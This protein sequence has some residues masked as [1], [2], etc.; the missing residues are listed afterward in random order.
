MPFFA[1]SLITIILLPFLKIALTS[2]LDR[3]DNEDNSVPRLGYLKLLRHKRVLFSGINQFMNIIIFVA[4]QP[5]FGPRL[6]DTYGLSDFVIGVMFAIAPITYI[7]SGLIFFPLIAKKFEPRTSMICG[8]IIL[9]MSCFALGPS[10]LLGFPDKSLALMVIGLVTLGIGAAFAV[11]PII[12]EMLDAVDGKYPEY[13]SEISDNFSGIFNVAGG[14]GQ[15]IGPSIA[16]AIDDKFGFNWTFDVVALVVLSY[17][18]I[19]ILV[20]G[21]IGS[22]A[23]SI[24]ATVLR[25]RKSSAEET[26]DEINNSPE[27]PA[28]QRLLNDSDEE[29]SLITKDNYNLSLDN[30]NVSTDISFGHQN[31]S[32]AINKED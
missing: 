20:C 22:F 19:Y 12:P 8:L 31:N 4:G 5:L 6:E 11:L 28:K 32:Y 26:I 18:L 29:D 27:S 24:K 23:R 17:L 25:F 10:N 13:Q 7:L 16:G 14:L 1:F 15:I 9:G 21:G 2:D 30:E 3:V